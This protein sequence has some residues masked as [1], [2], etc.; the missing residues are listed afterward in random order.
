MFN[1]DEMSEINKLTFIYEYS[2]LMVY[3]TQMYM[4]LHIHNQ[5]FIFFQDFHLASLTFYS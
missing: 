3:R 4:Y 5:K 2:A 1:M